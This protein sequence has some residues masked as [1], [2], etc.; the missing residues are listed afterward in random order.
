MTAPYL[1]DRVK[2]RLRTEARLMV[3]VYGAALASLTVSPALLWVWIV[4]MILGQP[5]LRLYLLAE[6]G[7]C[8]PVANMLENTRTTFTNRLVR[9]LAWNMP[10]HIEHHSAPNVPFHRLP[11]L[12][13][14]MQ[15]HLVTTAPGYAAFT[16]DYLA[17]LTPQDEARSGQ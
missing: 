6:H 10:F 4:P 16:K 3:A 9:W 17:T 7:R 2:P 15:D 5:A 14:D 13:R 12:H 8:P 1:P 11:D